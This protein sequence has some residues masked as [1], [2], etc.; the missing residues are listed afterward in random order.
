[1]KLKVFILIITIFQTFSVKT[2]FLADLTSRLSNS[3][4]EEK[5]NMKINNNNN[6]E[7]IVNPNFNELVDIFKFKENN[8]NSE[9]TE[10]NNNPN[11]PLVKEKEMLIY[12]SGTR[13]ELQNKADILGDILNEVK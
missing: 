2:K 6:N 7:S 4:I 3:S 13:N 9:S 11:V 5:V 12:K 1:M 8:K 10:I